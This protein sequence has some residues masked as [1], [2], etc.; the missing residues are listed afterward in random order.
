MSF[1]NIASTVNLL[2]IDEMLVPMTWQQVSYQDQKSVPYSKDN[3][4]S[5]D[6]LRI[7]NE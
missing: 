6:N 3:V 5:K 4:R 2:F 7:F 1:C